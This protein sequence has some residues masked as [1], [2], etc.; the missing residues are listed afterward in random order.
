MNGD[1]WMA[2]GTS[3]IRSMFQIFLIYNDRLLNS[4]TTQRLQAMWDAGRHWNSFHG[5]TGG[6]ICHDLWESTAR[7]V[8]SA[9]RPRYIVTNPLGN[10]IHSQC[11]KITGMLSV[12]I[13][14]LSSPNH[15]VMML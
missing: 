3:M 8:I 10:C 2:S 15:M 1:R 4:T 13:S 12:S 9:F 14:S 5:T 7:L 11:Q 6:P